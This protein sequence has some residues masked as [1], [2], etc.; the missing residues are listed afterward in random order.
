MGLDMYLN[1]CYFIGPTYE[2][3]NDE[4]EK[5]YKQPIKIENDTKKILEI[6]SSRISEIKE[7]V[8]YWRG[9]YSINKWF[10]DNTE[11]SNDEGIEFRVSIDELKK[12]LS[13]CKKVMEL[14]YN[15]A[16]EIIPHHTRYFFTT[17]ESRDKYYFNE[18]KNTIDI[19]EKIDFSSP[20]D[21]EFKYY[22]SF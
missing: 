22:A 4:L 7:E 1:K 5:K 6:N 8:G 13:D 14:D 16:Q 9:A 12:L 20:E 15:S 19:I 17:E 10:E 21:Y 18:I 2:V 11:E 3:V